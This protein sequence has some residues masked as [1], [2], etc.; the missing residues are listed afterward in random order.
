MTFIWG[1]GLGTGDG[2]TE[3]A[4][5]KVVASTGT[6]IE[7]LVVSPHDDGKRVTRIEIADRMDLKCAVSVS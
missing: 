4:E 1:E 7:A 2:N 6:A 3:R 5:V